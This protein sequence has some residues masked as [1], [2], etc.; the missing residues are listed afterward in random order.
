M[1][2]RQRHEVALLD[3]FIFQCIDGARL[4]LC[5]RL[6]RTELPTILARVVA[7]D[8]TTFGGSVVD[9]AYL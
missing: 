5:E 8:C 1:N 3:S 2:G 9:D 6:L 4:C 7:R